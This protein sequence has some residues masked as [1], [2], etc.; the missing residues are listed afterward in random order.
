MKRK[1]AVPAGTVGGRIA[2]TK[3]PAYSRAADNVNAR[4]ASPTISGT[5]ALAGMGRPIACANRRANARGRA[6]R[7]GSAS[8]MSKA[9]SAAAADAGGR[10]VE[11]TKLRARLCNQAITREDAQI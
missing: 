10:P 5:I 8:K 2:T 4:S 3:Y 9:V 11:Y 7:P 1:R 6:Q